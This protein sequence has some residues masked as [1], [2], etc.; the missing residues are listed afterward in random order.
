MLVLF[1]VLSLEQVVQSN[2]QALPAFLPP[3]P[4]SSSWHRYRDR[5][6]VRLVD[7]RLHDSRLR[8]IIHARTMRR[9]GLPPPAAAGVLI[10]P[11]NLLLHNNKNHHKQR[12]VPFNVV[13]SSY[14]DAH[15]VNVNVNK[16]LVGE[17]VRDKQQQLTKVGKNKKANMV[18]TT[19]TT[20]LSS[21]TKQKI[22][23]ESSLVK[24][25]TKR[26]QFWQNKPAGT[27]E[28]NDP[29]TKAGHSTDDPGVTKNELLNSW[30]STYLDPESNRPQRTFQSF[31]NLTTR[32]EDIVLD[33][34]ADEEEYKKLMKTVGAGGNGLGYG[35][36]NEVMGSSAELSDEELAG[37][38]PE[39]MEA[40]CEY[41]L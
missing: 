32:K 38:S 19:S 10:T 29:L 11:T 3:A 40:R 16:V 8:R 20:A 35:E 36:V 2:A 15:L 25:S 9:L 30:R 34:K 1:S 14:N 31:G 24:F 18:I 22:P 26:T 37:M 21:S 7:K 13:P 17:N 12:L 5:D 27:N 23:A 39:E 6:V 28:L 41:S 4:S 33:E